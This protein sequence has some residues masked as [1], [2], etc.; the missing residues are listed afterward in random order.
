MEQAVTVVRAGFRVS[1]KPAEA[2]SPPPILG[3]HTDEVL[4]EFGYGKNEIE[5]L[6]SEGVL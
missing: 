6:R 5:K 2:A 1:G 3:Q 4:A